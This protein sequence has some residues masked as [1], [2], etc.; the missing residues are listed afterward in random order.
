MGMRNGVLGNFHPAFAGTN[1]L[2]QEEVKY[3]EDLQGDTRSDLRKRVDAANAPKVDETPLRTQREG[4]LAALSDSPTVTPTSDRMVGPMGTQMG[5]RGETNTETA[6]DL[7]NTFGEFFGG[8]TYEGEDAMYPYKDRMQELEQEKNTELEK[9]SNPTIQNDPTSERPDEQKVKEIEEKQAE[10][11]PDLAVEQMG[12]EH[13][14]FA[15]DWEKNNHFPET[16]LRF[17]LNVLDGVPISQA[18]VDAG[19]FYDNRVATDKRN[20]YREELLQEGYSPESIEKWVTTGMQDDLVDISQRDL[21][22]QKAQ[23][24]LQQAQETLRGSQLGNIKAQNELDAYDPEYEQKIKDLELQ[25]KEAGVAVQRAT[26]NNINS[27]IASR[28]QEKQQK[29]TEA[30]QKAKFGYNRA[31]AGQEIWHGNYGGLGTDYPLATFLGNRQLNLKDGDSIP[32]AILDI[33]SPELAKAQAEEM[34]FLSGILRPESGAAIG[35][36]EWDTYGRFF[37][38]RRGDKPQD[39]ARKAVFRDL[40]TESL[41]VAAINDQQAEQMV[42]ILTNAL[43][44][45]QDYN[46]EMGAVKMQDGQWYSLEELRNNYL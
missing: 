45:V 4:V 42:G 11:L 12:R 35:M 44:G 46:R 32:K 39:V 10:F 20:A 38:P 6:A 17:F 3:I 15:E 43:A 16:A 36:K 13:R 40:T 5:I 7:R 33:T 28:T 23:L 1:D 2:T 18:Y 24:G 37:F 25:G 34:G 29:L 31:K 30:Q 41:N 14:G 8:R 22:R 19:S 9:G 21:E 26:L 27:Q